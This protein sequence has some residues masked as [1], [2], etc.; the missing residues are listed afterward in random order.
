MALRE[1]TDESGVFWTVYDVNPRADDRRTG[2]RRKADAP[3][4]E[5]ERRQEDRRVAVRSS[6]PVR[7][8][9]GWLCFERE[10]ERRRLQ[11][12]PTDWHLM[13]EEELV[14]LLAVATAARRRTENNLSS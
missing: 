13:P 3:A 7:L 5:E 10:G 1:F 4:P 11:P 14:K 12:I 2:D 6:R 9:K 8:T